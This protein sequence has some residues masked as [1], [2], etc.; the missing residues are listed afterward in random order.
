MLRKNF[1]S[2]WELELYVFVVCVPPTA[3]QTSTV[4]MCWN[5]FGPNFVDELFLQ[6]V[7]RK[8]L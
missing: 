5:F 6:M 3:D 8:K 4:R 2:R 1:S 7:L